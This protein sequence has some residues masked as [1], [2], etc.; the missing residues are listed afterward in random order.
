MS[1]TKSLQHLMTCS[2]SYWPK[3]TSPFQLEPDEDNLSKEFNSIKSK[4]DAFV[5]QTFIETDING[6]KQLAQRIDK[7]KEC[8][9]IS[10]RRILKKAFI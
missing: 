9:K 7:F 4:I 5:N 10:P 2:L 8:S 1:V 3:E 6:L